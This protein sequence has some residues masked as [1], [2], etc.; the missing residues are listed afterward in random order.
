[1]HKNRATAEATSAYA[2]RH[3][4]LAGNFR[5]VIGLDISSIGIG[6][7]L[8]ET[9][10]ETDHAY[11]EALAAALRGGINLI[12]TAVNYRF[13]RSE[14]NIGKVIN[15]LVASKEIKREEIVVATKGGYITFDGGVPADPRKWFEEKF[16]R[17]GIVGSGDMVEGSHCMTP[18]YLA[19]ML[20]M[21]R[22]NL[23][24]ETI[25][26]Y[27][28]H[29][30]ET[31]LAAVDRKEFL[32]R[33][34][35]AFEFLERAVTENKIAYYGT[36]TWNGYRAQQTERGWLSLDELLRA[37][38]EVAG[39]AHHFRAIQLPY[40]LAMPEAV[41]LANQGAPNE[42][43]TAVAVAKTF[44][45][46]VCASASLLQGKLSQGLPEILA[47]AFPSLTTD[48]QRAVQFVRSTPGID[49]ALVGMKSVPHV[50]EILAGAK[51][52]PASREA[53]LKLFRSNKP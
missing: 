10:E 41:T 43:T 25:D 38:R 2:S 31:Q 20:E 36:A 1:M 24:L 6:T 8:G 50:E 3:S 39:D 23:G 14:R 28:L 42:K 47:E 19:T 40:N 44:D 22:A 17:T 26:I 27:Y 16:V 34:G 5:K 15:E 29:N 18:K 12:D 35:K 32:A 49:V 13:Q 51:Q 46:A 11:E 9:D 53:L 21:S 30:P 48:A 4:N 37:A 52:P 33:I 7:Y 45:M